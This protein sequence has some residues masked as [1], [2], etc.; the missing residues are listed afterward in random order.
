V[1]PNLAISAGDA[2]TMMF[3]AEVQLPMQYYVQ[4]DGGSQ[5]A[6][7]SCIKSGDRELK[8]TF[9]RVSS[10]YRIDT[11]FDIFVRNV[12]NPVSFKPSSPFSQIKLVSRYGNEI[13]KFYDARMVIKT[14]ARSEI[15]DFNLSQS[16]LSSGQEATY[17]ISF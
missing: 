8:V 2:L 9:G 1:T 3:P 17:T 6:I 7:N 4:C 11:P 10:G 15:S 13:A 16:N 5:V 14:N 12:V